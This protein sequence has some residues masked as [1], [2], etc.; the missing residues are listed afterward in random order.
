ML[1]EFALQRL[2]HMIDEAELP[3]LEIA[4]EDEGFVAGSNDVVDRWDIERFELFRSVAGR[5]SAAQVEASGCPVVY[6]KIVPFL[7]MAPTDVIERL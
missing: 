1:T 3:V 7:P 5:R 6:V 2:G 4:M